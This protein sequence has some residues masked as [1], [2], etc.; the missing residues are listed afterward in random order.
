M[1]VKCA[2]KRPLRGYCAPPL[3]KA[4][5]SVRIF[6]LTSWDFA[7]NQEYNSKGLSHESNLTYAQPLFLLRE[8]NIHFDEKTLEKNAQER[9]LYHASFFPAYFYAATST[10]KRYCPPHPRWIF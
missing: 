8:S 9:T 7:L 1:L 10:G 2:H 6:G 3:M 4:A 5:S